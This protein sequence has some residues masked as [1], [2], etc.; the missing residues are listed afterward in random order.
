MGL[1][2]IGLAGLGMSL[3]WVCEPMNVQRWV[4]N[5]N[6]P[7]VSTHV[8]Q[9]RRKQ[10]TAGTDCHPPRHVQT[11]H[12]QGEMGTVAVWGCTEHPPVHV[13]WFPDGVF[14]VGA[15]LP[16][17]RAAS[18][19]AE[20]RP[21]SAPSAAMSA[22]FSAEYHEDSCITIQQGATQAGHSSSSSSSSQQI[23]W[24]TAGPTWGKTSTPTSSWCRRL[25]VLDS[26][27]CPI[28]QD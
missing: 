5:Y 8:G 21:I 2:S 26:P 13:A 14:A 3:G 27:D 15:A 22:V 23:S 9:V 4:L 10:K 17:A 28:C 20:P 6:C 11:S 12:S 24:A 19:P 16:T 7:N 25:T 1:R 18:I